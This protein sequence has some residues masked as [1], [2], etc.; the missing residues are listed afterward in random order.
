[1]SSASSSKKPRSRDATLTEAQKVDD[2]LK[3]IE[4]YAD[5]SFMES[6]VFLSDCQVDYASVASTTLARLII[7]S[8]T[9]K[10]SIRGL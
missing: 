3:N 9:G 1:M 6:I 5:G 4:G 8:P 10:A 7:L 2:A